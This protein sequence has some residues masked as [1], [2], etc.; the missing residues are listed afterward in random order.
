MREDDI[1]KA[2]APFNLGKMLEGV[3]AHD[4]M[5]QVTLAIRRED[6]QA[7]E[8]TRA[9]IEARLAGLPGV[10]NATVVFTAHRQ[11]PAPP[12]SVSLQNIRNII[13]VAS[14]KGRGGEIHRCGQSG[15]GAGAR[16]SAGRPAGCGYLR[17]VAAAHAGGEC[18]A[19]SEGRPDPAAACLGAGLH[20]DRLPGARGD[21]D[22]LARADGD[23]GAEPDADPGGV[24]AARRAGGGYA[25]GHRR[26]SI[27]PGAENQIA[28]RGGGIDAAGY[29]ADRRPARG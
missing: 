19:G 17:A 2:L 18:E 24:G 12:P 28:R 27:E 13:A 22:D 3:H 15:G 10:K 29:R 23:R 16:R 25:A 5:V 14:G 8:P 20:V 26:Y 7:L 4:G 6:A 11:P 9:K 21:R 1:R